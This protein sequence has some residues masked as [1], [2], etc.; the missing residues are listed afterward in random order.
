MDLCKE[1]GADTVI[2]YRSSDVPTFLC[3]NG[4]QFDFVLDNVGEPSELYWKSPSFTKHQAKYVQ[5]GSQVSIPFVY[6]LAFRFLVPTWLGG[7]QRPFSFGLA[8]T[9]YEDFT[10]LVQ[11]VADRK[12]VPLIDE[13]F[14]F[15]DVPQA[16][17]KLKKGRTKGKIVIHIRDS[18]Q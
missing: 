5:I 17:E 11:L 14:G 8:S 13:T 12:V 3:A 6:D 7:G 15:A 9:N 2:D 4:K 18:A 10:K 16:Y 1:L